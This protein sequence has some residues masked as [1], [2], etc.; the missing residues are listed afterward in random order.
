MIKLIV[1]LGNPGLQYEKTRHNA[2]FIFLDKLLKTIGGSWQGLRQFDGDVAN[3]TIN[4]HKL[5]LLKP[6]LYM[7]RSGL[8][9]GK[10]MR[11]Y[12]FARE[13]ILV[14][15]DELDLPE[16]EIRLKHDGGHA[17]HN[18]LRDII[19][20]VDGRDFYRMRIGIGRPKVGVQVADYVL[21]NY[22]AKSLN[23]LNVIFDA[24][25]KILMHLIQGDVAAFNLHAK[26][27]AIELQK[28]S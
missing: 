19:A 18:G 6:M 24:F 17:G 8:S 2:G 15:H 5:M 9:V 10:L 4:Q 20:H 11:Y 21:S 25:N 7:N 22:S 16:G 27:I 3:I 13:E 28:S 23:E 12:K 1:G 14:V 26:Q